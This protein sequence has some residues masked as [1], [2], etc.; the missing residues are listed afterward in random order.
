MQSGNYSFGGN[1]YNWFQPFKVKS[2]YQSQFDTLIT[3]LNPASVSNLNVVKINCM[4]VTNYRSQSGSVD[5]GAPITNT[6]NVW[7]AYMN[8]TNG[9]STYEEGNK[10]DGILY[11]RTPGST[12]NASQVSVLCSMIL[13]PSNNRPRCRRSNT[14]HSGYLAW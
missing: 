1:A 12:Q 10:Y 11:V 13:Y 14:A 5:N 3:R 6:P 4:P 8:A 2:S 7:A 9:N